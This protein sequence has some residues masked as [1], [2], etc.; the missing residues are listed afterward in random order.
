MGVKRADDQ[1]PEWGSHQQPANDGKEIGRGKE[2][3]NK[4]ITSRF[5][6]RVV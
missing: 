1:R 6:R 2:K 5:Y 4:R 3:I